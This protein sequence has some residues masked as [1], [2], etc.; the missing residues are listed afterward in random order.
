MFRNMNMIQ[1]IRK[2]PK[3]MNRQMIQ[4]IPLHYTKLTRQM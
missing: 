1:E 2:C 4:E 3:N